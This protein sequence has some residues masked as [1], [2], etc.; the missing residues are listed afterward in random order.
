MHMNFAH[1][2]T[3][4][5]THS[6]IRVSFFFFFTLGHC[7][8]TYTLTDRK[9]CQSLSPGRQRRLLRYHDSGFLFLSFSS[10]PLSHGLTQ[11]DT[12]PSVAGVHPSHPL[13]TGRP[14]EPGLASLY[15]PHF[16]SVSRSPSPSICLYLTAEL[17]APVW[18]HKFFSISFINSKNVHTSIWWV[19]TVNKS[20]SILTSVKK[21]HL[22]NVCCNNF[23]KSE[24]F[25]PLIIYYWVIFNNN[26]I[27]PGSILFRHWDTLC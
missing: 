20:E 14:S 23:K 7:V 21:C 18:A 6:L 17:L 19:L 1:P 15:L 16:H 25:N 8:Y 9:W 10:A 26:I 11:I 24:R 13:I 22:A 5:M 4:I 27:K 2:L 12:S 3:F